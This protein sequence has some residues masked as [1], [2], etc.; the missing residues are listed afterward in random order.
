MRRMW[1]V[2]PIMDFSSFYS[3]LPIIVRDLVNYTKLN[4]N[5]IFMVILIFYV[6]GSFFMGRPQEGFSWEHP[7]KVLIVT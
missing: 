2:N 3:I 6:Y 4:I 5:I 1:D 7:Y